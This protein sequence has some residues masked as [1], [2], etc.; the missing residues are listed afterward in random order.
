MREL[1][2]TSP[3]LPDL[4]DFKKSLDKIWESKQV[5]NNGEFH[6]TFEKALLVHLL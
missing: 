5:T 4:D 1:Y 3:L 6:Q 2:V